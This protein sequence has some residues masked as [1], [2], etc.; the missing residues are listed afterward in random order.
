TSIGF[1]VHK[2]SAPHVTDTEFFRVTIYIKPD[3]EGDGWTGKCISRFRTLCALL[4]IFQGIFL[5]NSHTKINLS[6]LV[7]R[8]PPLFD[9]R[10]GPGLLQNARSPK[11]FR[12]L[13][14]STFY[15]MDLQLSFNSPFYMIHTLIRLNFYC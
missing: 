5:F 10:P 2:K 13:Y 4:T 11:S 1:T 14:L 6:T 8:L 12:E 15:F 7:F 9:A 3:D